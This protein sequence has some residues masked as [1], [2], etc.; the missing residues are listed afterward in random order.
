M[1]KA[2]YFDSVGLLESTTTDGSGTDIDT[3]N[4]F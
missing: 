3:D 4:K 1:A 2:F